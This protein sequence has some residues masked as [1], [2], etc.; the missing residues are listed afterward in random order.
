MDLVFYMAFHK[1]HTVFFSFYCKISHVFQV[2]ALAM[3]DMLSWMQEGGQV[4]QKFGNHA[5]VL[6]Y[7]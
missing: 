3:E 4:G 2:A 6:F 5:L 1:G 7:N